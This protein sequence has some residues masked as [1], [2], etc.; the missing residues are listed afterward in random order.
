MWWTL[1]LHGAGETA[2][3]GACR[4]KTVCKMLLTIP[5]ITF[6]LTVLPCVPI[7]R[8]LPDDQQHAAHLRKRPEEGRPQ[9]FVPLAQG[10]LATPNVG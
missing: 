7:N 1:S 4:A 8:T 10:S 2:S 6:I 3:P 5:Y 9:E